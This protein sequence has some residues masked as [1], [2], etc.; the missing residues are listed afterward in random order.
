M[1]G[2]SFKG[3]H[4]L[5]TMALVGQPEP[6]EHNI[7][8]F[9]MELTLYQAAVIIQMSGFRLNGLIQWLVTAVVSRRVHNPLVTASSTSSSETATPDY[10]V[11]VKPDEDLRD[12]GELVPFF[13]GHMLSPVLWGPTMMWIDMLILPSL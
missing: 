7:G 5:R 2:V 9:Y 13:A 8:W 1:Q 6:V 12:L 4:G 11:D 3:A 10:R